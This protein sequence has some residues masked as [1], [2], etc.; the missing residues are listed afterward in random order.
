M[1]AIRQLQSAVSVYIRKMSSSFD[2]ENIVNVS[3]IFIE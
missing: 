2:I 1:A 3:L